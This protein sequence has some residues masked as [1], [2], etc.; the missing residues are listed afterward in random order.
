MS[1]LTHK[2]E[3]FIHEY[4]VDFNATQAAIRAGYSQKTAGKIGTEN[5]QK[6]AISAA[7]RAGV[8]ELLGK[9]R[10]TAER[11][12]LEQVRLALSDM[13]DFMTWG[14]SGIRMRDSEELSDDAAA[15]IS[16]VSETWNPETGTRTR[17]FKLHS[18]QPALDTLAKYFK[19]IGSDAS[20]A[21]LQ[22]NVNVDARQ[23]EGPDLSVLTDEELDAYRDTLHK[24][25]SSSSERSGAR[26]SV[27]PSRN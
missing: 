19:L 12:L 2:Q 20:G 24:L 16:E 10:L 14:A 4:L 22:V 1:N 13:R 5:L 6:P 18:K 26:A 17:K 3:L 11:V 25:K 21:G 8:D 27:F 23:Q 7:I 15:A 9:T